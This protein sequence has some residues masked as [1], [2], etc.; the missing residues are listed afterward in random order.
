MRTDRCDNRSRLEYQTKRNRKGNKYNSL[1]RNMQVVWNVKCVMLPL[2]TG[3]TGILTKF[4]KKIFWNSKPERWKLLSFKKKLMIIII[5]I[6]MVQKNLLLI[7][8]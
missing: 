5:I 1:Y 4:L 7:L 2:I 8:F 3:A 6:I